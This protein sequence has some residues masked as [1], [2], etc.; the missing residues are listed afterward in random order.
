M[1][2]RVDPK[3][4]NSS[5][6]QIILRYETVDGTATGGSDYT[7][8][9]STALQIDKNS[10]TS[11]NAMFINIPVTILDDSS[12]ET[13][14]YFELNITG[15]SVNNGKTV[16]IPYDPG[17]ITIEDDDITTTLPSI[18]INSIVVNEGDATAEF[19]VSLDSTTANDVTFEYTSA[20][21]NATAGAD[22]SAVY[23]TTT[24][25]AGTLE[26]NIT[27]PIIDDTMAGEYAECFYVSIANIQNANPGSDVGT[28]TIIDNDTLFSLSI[29]DAAIAE[30][31]NN[32]TGSIN[33]NF[34]QALSSDMILTYHTTDD[35][36]TAPGDYG[37][38]SNTVAVPTGSS[39]YTIDITITGD[40]VAESTESFQVILD[41]ATILSLPQIISD[42]NGTF[43]IFDD[44]NNGTCSSYVGL[45]T[46]NEY[47]NNP[48]YFDNYT[49]G[50]HTRQCYDFVY[51]TDFDSSAQNKDLFRIPDGTGDWFDNGNGTVDDY[52]ACYVNNPDPNNQQTAES[53]NW[54]AIRPQA[55]DI[56]I[57]ADQN[58]TAGLDTSLLFRAVDYLNGASNDY[59][60]TENN[61]FEINVSTLLSTCDEPAI[62]L[63][64]DV[65]FTNG[66]ATDTFRF[67]NIGEVNLT[68]SEIAGAEFARIDASDTPDATRYI[69]PKSVVFNLLPDHFEINATLKDFG[70]Q[71]T[72]LYDINRDN[73][74]TAMSALLDV[75]VSALN[76]QN[77]LATN[78]TQDCYAN[79]TLLTLTLVNPIN[80]TPLNSGVSPL[81]QFLWFNSAEYNAS[82]PNSGEGNMTLPQPALNLSELNI[83]NTADSFAQSGKGQAFLSYRLNFDRN[84]SLVVN[85]FMLWLQDV[86]I[87]DAIDG[88]SAPISLI[89]ENNATF[90]SGRLH[91]PRYRVE[92]SGSGS[93]T[94][95]ATPNPPLRL[96]GEFYYDTHLTLDANTTLTTLLAT[97][98]A[99]RS[100]DSI[101]WYTNNRHLHN[102]S[103][104]LEGTA[105]SVAQYYNNAVYS[106]TPLSV[107]TPTNVNAGISTVTVTYNGSK[108]YPYKASMGI[109]ASPWL[110]YNRFDA[111]ASYNAF[112]LEFNAMHLGG[113]ANT[114]A[115]DANFTNPNTSRRI[116]W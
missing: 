101:L 99:Q 89:P 87:T 17:L 58:I 36:A 100:V 43:T 51:D 12:V 65:N 8:I 97:T 46:I 38:V 20:D 5:S 2:I 14:E 71:Y 90:L 21:G 109:S 40:D 44:D 115:Q 108:S 63:T 91:A 79:A 30:A 69:T 70:Q 3:I 106:S 6:D 81:K 32:I 110:L 66:S 107:T 55:F 45:M 78:Y 26:T 105:L 59:N 56:N 85:P 19:T 112:E 9:S 94:T 48:N 25:L 18:S 33:V 10:P 60:E 16:A 35:T 15:A 49:G 95:A 92:C 57:S 37:S 34:S 41:S 83:S 98:G 50:N 96:Y 102:G 93:C 39:S 42:S 72:Y 4:R 74:Y 73:N 13:D 80:I 23:G 24:I 103:S 29:N 111:N 114:S 53:R 86:N 82:I 67:A 77:E 88:I 62:A 28:A 75:N 1:N 64:P 68:I 22:Y 84:R 52:S 47:Q 76:A 11:G 61:S 116:R 7:A 104:A 31:D 54:L 113:D 27:V